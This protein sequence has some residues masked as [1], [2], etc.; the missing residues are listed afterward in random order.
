MISRFSSIWDVWQFYCFMSGYIKNT[1][2][3]NSFFNSLRPKHYHLHNF[4]CKS[5][6]TNFQNIPTLKSCQNTNILLIFSSVQS[7]LALQYVQIVRVLPLICNII[8]VCCYFFML[9]LMDSFVVKIYVLTDMVEKPYSVSIS[10]LF[11]I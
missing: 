1:C 7:R 9:A 11:K 8:L 6:S 2:M 4:S 5:K 3:W 10:C